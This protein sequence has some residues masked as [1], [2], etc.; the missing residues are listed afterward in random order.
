MTATAR[1]PI[2]LP[3]FLLALGIASAPAWAE[4]VSLQIV[5]REPFAGGKEFGAVGAYERISGIAR[6][7]VDPDHRRNRDIVDL[8]LAPRN[9]RGKVEFESDFFILAPKDPS[10]G[11]GA[12][13]YEVNNRGLKLAL[14][15]FNGGT[16]T[17]DPS[18][19]ADAGD[20]F[21]FRRGYT[22][23]WCGWIGELVPGEGRLLLRPP[24]ALED[25]RPLRGIVRFETT[26]NAPAETMP[27]ARREGLGSYAPTARGEKEGVLTWRMR[28]T[29][30]R[31]EIPK[32]QW[33][34]ER[35]TVTPV[36]NA[37][38]G[39]LAPVRLRVAGGFRPGYLYELVC[40]AEGSVVQGTGYLAV[41]DLVS[42]LRYG[43]ED[44]PFARSLTRA[45]AFGISQ[46][47][48]F[49]RNLV[50]LDLNTDEAGRKVFDGLIPDVAG[51]GL[52]FFNHRFS[53]ASRY[54]A[55]H[56]EHLYPCDRFPFT[57][58]DETDPYLGRTDG[59][60]RR[61]AAREPGHL[62]KIFHIQHAAEYWHRS[63]SLV[64]TDPLGKKDVAIPENV[65]VYAFGGIQH[66]PTHSPIKVADHPPSPA[67]P[68]PFLKALLDA[69]DGWVRDG[70]TPPPSVM[71]RID[72]GTLVLPDLK[73]TGFPA[74]PGVR[75]PAV[76]QRPHALDF[77][78]DFESKGRI[79][80]EPPRLLGDYVVR[81]PRSDADG[82]DEGT[83]LL[84]EILVPLATYTGWNLRG[85]EVGAEGMLAELMGS[86]IAF[87]RT[88][89]EREARGDPR[90][91]LEE[92]YGTFEAYR[93][94]FAQACRKLVEQRYFLQEDADGQIAERE[95][96]R[97]LFR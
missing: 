79:A 31:V 50:H 63:G 14:R 47:G 61:T 20:G 71:P 69:L 73:S 15:S 94:R 70:T 91:S 48:R 40:E 92:R 60:L 66:S 32:A 16:Q 30:P 65:R 29:D 84:P 74:I 35:G 38:P 76:I 2:V 21:L 4:L 3:A 33:S 44:N 25:G 54:N 1:R 53:Q 86:H 10:K 37:V 8:S 52:G 43:G 34:L 82:N 90:P 49:L 24:T 13:F 59:I 81:V 36:E 12:L 96:V 78:P 56:E 85:R 89:T 17:N 62:P 22:V 77:G 19:E 88:R 93:T 11:N 23:V 80:V 97:F 67:D 64:H 57:Y 58:G 28:E 95:R 26:A 87:A 68:Q 42:F 72:Q 55:Q 5:R 83:L 39:T 6:F 75:F 27:L 51:G 46:S 9:A 41:R 7:A 18:T 45:H